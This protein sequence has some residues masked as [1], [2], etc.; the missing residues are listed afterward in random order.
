M[1][2]TEVTINLIELR[3]D[4]DKLR[5]Y[6]SFVLDGQ[7][8]VHDCKVVEASPGRLIVCMPNRK[9]TTKCMHCH[10][11][12]P[13]TD[14]YCGRCGS[15]SVPFEERIQELRRPNGRLELHRDILHP[16]DIDFRVMI[17]RAILDRYQEA[18]ACRPTA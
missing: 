8:V 14:G 1:K 2:V 13:V 15:E 7:F 12:Y 18:I 6:V 10:I 16:L 11:R 3:D 17:E 9:S 4:R 5:A